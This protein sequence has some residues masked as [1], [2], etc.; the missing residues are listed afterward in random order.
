MNLKTENK[1]RSIFSAWKAENR[2]L[3]ATKI[4]RLSKIELFYLVSSNKLTAVPE[5]LHDRKRA[6]CFENFIGNSLEAAQ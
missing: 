4:R 1:I 5:L 2:E 6:M 3:A